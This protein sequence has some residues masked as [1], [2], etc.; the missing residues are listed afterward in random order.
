[1]YILALNTN[2]F[3]CSLCEKDNHYVYMCLYVHVQVCMYI[4]V[5]MCMYRYAC[6]SSY[7]NRVTLCVC[8]FRSLFLVGR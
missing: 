7:S 5:C 8:I 3:L 4:C 6:I 1:M 2:T